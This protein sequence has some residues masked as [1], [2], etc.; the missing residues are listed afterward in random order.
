MCAV[1]YN[2]GNHVLCYIN[3]VNGSCVLLCY[4]VKVSKKSNL[5]GLL[6]CLSAGPVEGICNLS[7][8]LDN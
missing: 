7:L 4:A 1:N 5:D 8:G 6:A 3:K 2:V